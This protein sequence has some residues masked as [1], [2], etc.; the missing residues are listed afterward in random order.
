M[1]SEL[2]MSKS[3]YS[4]AIDINRVLCLA[5]E[6]RNEDGINY[7]NKKYLHYTKLVE[8]SNLLR[9]RFKED[10]LTN[11]NGMLH[12][13]DTSSEGETKE[14]ELE[15]NMAAVKRF[16]AKQMYSNSQRLHPNGRWTSDMRLK[17]LQTAAMVVM[18]I[19]YPNK[20]L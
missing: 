8:N 12:F 9:K 13:G 1:N 7:L 4:L 2:A 19:F 14:I 6:D 11:D 20:L 17:R 18:V 5:P 15:A 3:F 10:R 16:R